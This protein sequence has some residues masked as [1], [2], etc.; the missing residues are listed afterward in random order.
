MPNT[1]EVPAEMDFRPS[2]YYRL[3]EARRR[4]GVRDQRTVVGIW[5]RNRFTILEF[6]RVDRRVR[7]SDLAA[8]IA[9]SERVPQ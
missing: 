8:L 7:K 9:R 1:Q 3:S 6:S 5:K 2:D 4:L